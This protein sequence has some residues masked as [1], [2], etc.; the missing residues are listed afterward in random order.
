MTP[1]SLS[2]SNLCLKFQIH[3]S[4]D[5]SRVFHHS[6]LQI[7]PVPKKILISSKPRFSSCCFIS[8][9]WPTTSHLANC[10]AL[11]P[12]F[13]IWPSTA[14]CPWFGDY[15]LN[16]TYSFL[17]YSCVKIWW[18]L[19]LSGSSSPLSILHTTVIFNIWRHVLVCYGKICVPSD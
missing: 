14:S 15:K 7:V 6:E 12:V 4:E 3:L 2:N 8:Y 19:L 5:V 18:N 11:T 10:S 13:L 1:E 17:P 16:F 9:W